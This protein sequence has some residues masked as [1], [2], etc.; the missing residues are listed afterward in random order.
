MEISLGND[1]RQDHVITVLRFGFHNKK[2][3]ES[4]TYH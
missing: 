1:Q 4:I 2:G 3:N